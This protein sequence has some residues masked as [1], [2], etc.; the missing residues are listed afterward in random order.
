VI[1][2]ASNIA[3]AGTTANYSI[4][5]VSGATSYTWNVPSNA[6]I[7]SGQ[8][9]NAVSIQF[10]AGFSGGTL[11]VSAANACGASALRSYTI[12]SNPGMPSAMT[13]TSSNLCGL[14][15]VTYSVPLTANATSYNWTVPAFASIVSG[16]GTNA[17]TVNYANVS[18]SSGSVCVS[19]GNVCGSGAARC[20]TSITTL[21][22]RPS[23]ITG[24][25]TVCT[26]Q[27][28]ISYSVVTQPGAVY[29]WT[30]PAGC[31][32]VS[33][34]G[35]GTVVIN[36]GSV[37]GSIS[38]VASNSCGSATA[39]TLSVAIN[40]R[41]SGTAE[42]DLTVYP[43]PARSFA[44]VKLDGMQGVST[45]T[46]TDITGKIIS[47]QTMPENTIELN[48]SNL[49]SGI[50]LVKVRLENGSEKISRLAIE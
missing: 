5:A 1:S 23:V 28:N 27:Q 21:P 17:I 45:L 35:T 19:A 14:S 44:T 12:T 49:E 40:C 24:T 42:F 16:Q 43:N 3:C 15:N 30:V 47:V 2:S 46:L 10:N 13:G 4:V 31:S 34:Q 20:L 39:R 6:V 32:L 36:W 26:G 50:Y 48:L 38:V 11:S 37:G 7:L 8:G 25:A 9:T 22:L 33:G 41:V 18:G 29:T